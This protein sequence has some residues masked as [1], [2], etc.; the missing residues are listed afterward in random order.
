MPVP[1]NFP[2]AKLVASTT[3]ERSKS[4]ICRCLLTL[5]CWTVCSLDS[6]E[7]KARETYQ[8][9][10]QIVEITMV[11]G[12]V[13]SSS[14]ARN[15]PSLL[16][17][18][19]ALAC[20]IGLIIL[21]VISYLSID[22][23]FV[24]LLRGTGGESNKSGMIKS[25]FGRC[26]KI[27]NGRY[28]ASNEDNDGSEGQRFPED[29]LDRKDLLKTILQSKERLIEKLKVDYGEENFNRIFLR[30]TEDEL[31]DENPP[32]TNSTINRFEFRPFRPMSMH[33]KVH[34][35]LPGD[36][37]EN[38]VRQIHRKLIIKILSAQLEYRRQ[39]SNVDGCNCLSTRGK[40]RLSTRR[41]ER[42]LQRKHR[43]QSEQS[44][45]MPD[46]DE[47]DNV[48]AL[49]LPPTFSKMVWA[50]GGHS[51]AAGHG[52]LFNETYT[53]FMERNVK[54]V[55]S[56]IGI[57]F[58]AR[59]YAM[60]GTG[61]SP[62]LALCFEQIFGLDVDMFSWDFGMLEAGSPLRMLHYG[63][64][65]GLS[66]GRP[67]IVGI[68]ID[69][70]RGVREG[71][72]GLLE[73][74]GMSVF[75]QNNEDWDAMKDGIPETQGLSAEQL[76]SLPEYVRNFKCAGALETGE[77]FCADEKYTNICPDRIGKASWHQGL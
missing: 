12:L 65:G 77:P 59:N 64:R 2:S 7:D 24:Q 14:G 39:E 26:K 60:G 76:R 71:L 55:F 15:R 62:E 16:R 10:D 61:S 31:K 36:G 42:L 50:T 41:T 56:S 33:G 1:I 9:A 66:R 3:T 68:R 34:G 46:D 4:T 74:S 32:A 17:T 29:F 22:E 52:N 54:D 72:L 27:C 28:E 44:S 45:P 20:A 40:R 25:V 19:A 48:A 43:N 30:R 57:E 58:E 37:N 21:S 6:F 51:S 63:Y 49:H 53:A 47:T 69:N 38:S 67:A 75:Y 8:Q 13:G 73:D 23:S 35:N 18:H 5:G 70:D 11:D